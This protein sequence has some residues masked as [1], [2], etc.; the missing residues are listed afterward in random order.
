MSILLYFF[1]LLAPPL[2]PTSV[3]WVDHP[4]IANDYLPPVCPLQQMPSWDYYNL[5]LIGGDGR[6]LCQ[7][8]A[9]Q[10]ITTIPCATDPAKNYHIE[11][12]P[13]SNI[14]TGC[15]LWM[16]Q[17]QYSEADIASQCPDWLKDYQAGTLEIRGP[18]EISPSAEADNACTLPRVDNTA[19][20]G[21]TN[22]YQFLAGRLSWW[23]VDISQADW[24]NRWDEQ[25]RGAADAA[26]I[27][28]G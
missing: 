1:L 21:T 27:P 3:L 26:G 16:S 15:N 24:Q 8:P 6:V 13:N 25:I 9:I 20:I 4:P 11:V 17:P 2:S 7:W 10:S 14:A 18:Y 19:P 28:A 23:G 5:R 12:W 22:D